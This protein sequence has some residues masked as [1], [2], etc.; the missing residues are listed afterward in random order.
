MARAGAAVKNQA[1]GSGVGDMR[2]SM[3]TESEFQAQNG[4]GWVLMDGRNV[5][6]S[7]YAV[8][9]GVSVI[10]D[11]RGL[12]PRMKNNG[13][14]DGS[15]DPGGER[16]LGNFQDHAFNSHNHGGGS[17]THGISNVVRP[18]DAGQPNPD[19][20]AAGGIDYWPGSH[21]TNGPSTTVVALEGSTETRMR[22]LASNCFIK[23]N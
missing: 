8:L 4:T 6:G 23:I 17:H 3:L 9:K 13:R 11:H 2:W 1:D 10:P 14:S 18:D 5:A 16:A 22:N 21:N 7:R 20:D 19:V 12:V 15:Q